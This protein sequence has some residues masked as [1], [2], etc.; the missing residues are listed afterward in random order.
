MLKGEGF[1]RVA[2][3]RAGVYVE[4]RNGNI[5]SKTVLLQLLY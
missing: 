4:N 1:I 5:V 3:F 2:N